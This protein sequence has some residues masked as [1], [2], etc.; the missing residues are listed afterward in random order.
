MP[1]LLCQSSSPQHPLHHPQECMVQCARFHRNCKPGCCTYAVNTACH[2][3]VTYRNACNEPVAMHIIR[4]RSTIAAA[5]RAQGPPCS[6][7][8]ENNMITYARLSWIARLALLACILQAVCATPIHYEIKNVPSST[9]K[10]A[11]RTLHQQPAG[12][13]RDAAPRNRGHGRATRLPHVRPDRTCTQY[14]PLY[15]AIQ[16]TV[17]YWSAR[18]GISEEAVS[19]AIAACR[20][21]LNCFHF[22]VLPGSCSLRLTSIIHDTGPDS[23]AA[24]ASA[25]SSWDQ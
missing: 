4:P 13:T 14:K 6:S 12:S 15:A 18:G 20:R 21:E 16:R 10:Y 19:Q 11:A 8:V 25:A 17:E 23:T 5:V 9:V 3:A 7:S 2:I 24:S 1:K 22:K